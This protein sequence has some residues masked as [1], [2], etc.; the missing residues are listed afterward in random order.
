MCIYL[1]ISSSIR[2][3]TRVVLR[4]AYKKTLKYH[5]DISALKCVQSLIE[6]EHNI[7]QSAIEC[8]TTISHSL[9]Y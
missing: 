4:V 5:V 6:R 1:K 8:T 9:F 2:G 7:I 3:T